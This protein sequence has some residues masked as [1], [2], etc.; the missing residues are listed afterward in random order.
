MHDLA[1]F[2]RSIPWPIAFVLSAIFPL[3]AILAIG[4]ILCDEDEEEEE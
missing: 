2:F 1:E 4:I 3:M